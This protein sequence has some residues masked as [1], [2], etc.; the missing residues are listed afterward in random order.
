MK[1]AFTLLELSIVLVIIGLIVGGV[2]AGQEL[3]RNAELSAVA[4]EFGQYEIAYNVFRHKYNG[5]PGDFKAAEDYWNAS[6]GKS[7]IVNGNGDGR[8]YAAAGVTEH[9]TSF[10]HLIAAD[11]VK[12][13]DTD[14][15]TNTTAV[16]SKGFSTGKYWFVYITNFSNNAL[17][18]GALAGA[19]HNYNSVSN[20]AETASIDKKIDDGM[21]NTGRFRG[22]TA[23]NDA[24]G[25]CTAGSSYNVSNQQLTCYMV[26]L[27]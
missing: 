10:E 23:I 3:I 26:Y 4:R 22:S 14:S 9:Y 16:T 15:I 7:H 18:L 11:I 2:V 1:R 27:M 6:N 5:L 19:S 21:P 17:R 25:T 12:H 20:P 13:S 8:I 24:S